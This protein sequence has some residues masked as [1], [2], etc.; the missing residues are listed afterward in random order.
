MNAD[1]TNDKLKIN[2]DKVEIKVNNRIV[3]SGWVHIP[4]SDY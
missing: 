2:D 4:R 1:K 3:K